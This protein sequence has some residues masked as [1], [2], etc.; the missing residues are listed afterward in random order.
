MKPLAEQIGEMY[1]GGANKES[2]TFIWFIIIGIGLLYL[3][4]QYS[5]YLGPKAKLIMWVGI[6]LLLQG[7]FQAFMKFFM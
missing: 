5:E 7:L 1:S 6:S 3:Y 4:N 2:F